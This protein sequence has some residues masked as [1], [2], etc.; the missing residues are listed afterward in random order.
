LSQPEGAATAPS[1]VA[2]VVLA[3]GLSRRMGRRKLLLEVEGRP[4]VRWSVEAIAP[5]VDDVVVVTGPDDTAMREALA[6]LDVD[7]AENP[8]PEDGQGASIA[9]GI[10]AL[11][12]EV[13]AAIIA[14]GDQPT[15]PPDAI[16]LLFEA[17]RRTAKPIVAPVY[18]GTQGTPVLFAASVF[19]ELRA[20]TGDAGARRVVDRDPTRV[21]RVPIDAD[22]PVDVDTPDDLV[23]LA[24]TRDR[25]VQ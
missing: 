6:G 16:P 11:G 25:R 10:A 15:L 18:R 8:R 20:L 13:E 23:R 17:F 4:L 19:P 3:A 22:M 21:A 2:A 9:A 24:A 12:A 7:V 1:I 5:H 14:L